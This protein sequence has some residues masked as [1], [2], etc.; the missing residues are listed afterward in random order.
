MLRERR[1]NWIR[2]PDQL[3]QCSV[4]GESWIEEISCALLLNYHWLEI[5][6]QCYH[7]KRGFE[8]AS[9]EKG[10]LCK[11]HF[12]HNYDLSA[13][14][15]MWIEDGKLWFYT[16]GPNSYWKWS[17]LFCCSDL[18]FLSLKQQKVTASGAVALYRVSQT[19]RLASGVLER[20]IVETLFQLKRPPSRSH[21]VR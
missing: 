6:R 1:S 15:G 20:A 10:Y 18:L 17:H 19:N 8:A 13:D 14:F 9:V 16:T 5:I 3:I 21:R 2:E 12:H 11:T 7:Y 4:Q